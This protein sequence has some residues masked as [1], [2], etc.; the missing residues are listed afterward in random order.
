MIRLVALIVGSLVALPLWAFD[1]DTMTPEEREIFRQE[2]RAYLLDHPE[3]I[4]EA[5]DIHEQRQNAAQVSDDTNLIAGNSDMIFYDGHSW[6]GGNP[7]GDITIV[8]FLD[9]QCGYCRRAFPEVAELVKSDGNIRMIIKE[10]PILGDAS[11]L[12]ARFAIAVKQIRGDDAYKAAHDRMMTMRG[13]ISEPGLRSLALDLGLDYAAVR[14]EMGSKRTQTIIAS[15]RALANQL[16]INGTP[17]FVF[18]NEMLRGYVPL[19]GMRSIVA[20]LR[21][22]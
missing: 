10:F 18:E 2:V 7:E 11:V 13:G 16:G 1:I 15:N 3:V 19:D 14:H 6:V 4:F 22:G 8:E 21:G 17:S 20:R 12:G 5:V 9:Y